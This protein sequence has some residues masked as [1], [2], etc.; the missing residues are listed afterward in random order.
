M[1]LTP[2]QIQ[3]MKGK[4]V[5]P[6]QA[7]AIRKSG[8]QPQ[9]GTLEEWLSS[10]DRLQAWLVISGTKHQGQ[11]DEQVADGGDAVV[12]KFSDYVKAKG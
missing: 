2:G 12:Y 8:W 11:R 5:T 10:S 9:E 1:D 7:R 3:S 6:A 4:D